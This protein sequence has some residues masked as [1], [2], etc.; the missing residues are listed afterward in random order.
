VCARRLLFYSLSLSLSSLY[1]V[2][3]LFI[4]F[5]QWVCDRPLFRF[6]I[7]RFSFRNNGSLWLL[8]STR[9]LTP[10]PTY[11]LLRIA[12]RLNAPIR[13]CLITTILGF[14]HCST[15]TLHSTL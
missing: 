3:F 15:R 8:P 14:V 7:P 13:C 12:R 5:I 2:V 10:L 6:Y 9:S 1:K 4:C 11:S